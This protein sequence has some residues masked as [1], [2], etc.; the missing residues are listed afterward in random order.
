MRQRSKSRC[1]RWASLLS[2]GHFLLLFLACSL[3]PGPKSSTLSSFPEVGSRSNQGFRYQLHAKGL[4][5]CPFP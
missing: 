2:P 3:V 4:Q 5:L 1:G